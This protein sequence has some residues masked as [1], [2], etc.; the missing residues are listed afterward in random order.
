MTYTTKSS[1]WILALAAGTT[2]A[3]GLMNAA[4]H[5]VQQ[6][7]RPAVHGHAVVRLAPVIIMIDADARKA[8]RSAA[9]AA[10]GAVIG[11]KL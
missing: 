9:T 11:N 1:T 6:A 8:A 3:L 7:T 4:S 2:L 10:A 5:Y